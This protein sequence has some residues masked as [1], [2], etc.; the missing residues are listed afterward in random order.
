MK[1]IKKYVAFDGEE[2]NNKDTCISY[3]STLRKKQD[4]IQYV[5]A[6]QWEKDKL[7]INGK[8]YVR[9]HS[10]LIPV[11]IDDI[12]GEEVRKYLF[13]EIGD[14]YKVLA[15]SRKDALKT[16][17]LCGHKMSAVKNLRVA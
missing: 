8:R 17:E 5:T 4:D 14:T 10:A 13:D 2:F 7:I 12:I 3:E 15:W 6:K 16:I 9:K 11:K 1:E